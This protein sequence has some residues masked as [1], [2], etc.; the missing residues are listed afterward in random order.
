MPLPSVSINGSFFNAFNVPANGVPILGI[1]YCTPSL[2]LG[3]PPRVMAPD[4][5]EV[6]HEFPDVEGIGTTRMSTF[7]PRMLTVDLVFVSTSIAAAQSLYASQLS[8][9]KQLAR[10]TVAIRNESFAGCKLQGSGEFLGQGSLGGMSFVAY[11]LIFKQLSP[12]N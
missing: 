5:T 9:W 12:G 6:E 4:Y 8:S 11:S 3:G 2:Q 10:Y 7:G 1:Y